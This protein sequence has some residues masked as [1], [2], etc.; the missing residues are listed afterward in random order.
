MK[1]GEAS[2]SRGTGAEAWKGTEVQ[3]KGQK[4][5][6]LEDFVQVPRDQLELPR[7]L[8]LGR[9]TG[10]NVSCRQV[11]SLYLQSGFL[12][13]VS[14]HAVRDTGPWLWWQFSW[15]LLQAMMGV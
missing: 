5:G 6:N 1:G 15:P 9:L 3:P 8:P 11:L 7:V 10:H 12:P 2:G 13:E 4:A 14:S